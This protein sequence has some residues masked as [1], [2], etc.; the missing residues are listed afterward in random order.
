MGIRKA[1][2]AIEN[3][4]E[5]IDARS[6]ELH[7]FVAVDGD[8]ATGAFIDA[9]RANGRAFDVGAASLPIDDGEAG[10]ADAGT[11]RLRVGCILRVG[12]LNVPGNDRRELE[13]QIAQ[14]VGDIRTALMTPTNWDA[15]TSGI[16]SIEP[17]GVATRTLDGDI[18][19]VAV[20]FDML[21]REV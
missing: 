18:L 17:P 7:T 11:L 13:V 1:Y 21:Y 14:D 4:V 2:D 9:V 15:G 8:G 12:Y 3:A 10:A 16:I 19:T 6:A 20:P 5:S